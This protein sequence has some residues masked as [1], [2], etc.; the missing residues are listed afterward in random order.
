MFYRSFDI[1][2][3]KVVTGGTSG[4][5][6]NSPIKC[7]HSNRFTY[8]KRICKAPDVEETSFCYSRN[9]VFI[10]FF[11]EQNNLFSMSHFRER[12]THHFEQASELDPTKTV[13]LQ[14]ELGSLRMLSH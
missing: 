2:R 4:D 13:S 12:D 9:L 5:G 10:S 1:R 6:I 8:L 11:K 7:M 14:T 3:G